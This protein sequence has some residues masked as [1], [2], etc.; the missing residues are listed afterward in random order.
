VN[1]TTNVREAAKALRAAQRAYMANRG[2]EAHGKAVA[3]AAEALDVAL[4]ATEPAVDDVNKAASAFADATGYYLGKGQ[5]HAG[6]SSPS[7]D[8]IRNG[9]REAFA[10]V[11]FP[12]LK[13]AGLRLYM[14]GKWSCS[15]PVNEAQLWE[16][17]RDAL[18]LKPGTATKAGIH[19]DE[20]GLP[21]DRPG[22]DL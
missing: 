22:A 13:A 11:N 8:N 1:C 12:A 3:V 18:R 5:L 2:S 9:I 17:F 19:D 14:A 21:F 7:A 15:R 20:P 16:D 10:A 4:A 6:L